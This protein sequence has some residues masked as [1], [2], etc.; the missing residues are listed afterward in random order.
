MKIYVLCGWED[1]FTYYHLRYYLHLEDAKWGLNKIISEQDEDY[2][3]DE[4]EYYT[5]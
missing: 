1:D 3:Y 5:I 4:Y 2:F